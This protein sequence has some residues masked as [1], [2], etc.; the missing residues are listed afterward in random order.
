MFEDNLLEQLDKLDEAPRPP[1]KKPVLICWYSG[2]FRH[3]SGV[4]LLKD[5]TE[6]AKKHGLTDQL[7]LG[8]PDYYGITGEGYDYWPVYIDRL[9]TEIDGTKDYRN[10]PLIFFAHS[11]GAESALSLASRLSG[12][13]LKIYIAACG[14]ISLGQ[15]THWEHLSK[16]FKISGTRGLLSWFSQL[17]PSNIL[18]SRTSQLPT[19]EMEKAVKESKWLTETVDVMSVQYKDATFPNMTSD[20]PGI[21]VVDAPIV[22]ISPLFDPGC[23]PESMKAWTEN[24]TAECQMIT[25]CAGHMDCLEEQAG[26]MQRVG[27]DM[28]NTARDPQNCPPILARGPKEEYFFGMKEAEEA[29]AAEKAEAQRQLAEAAAAKKARRV[30]AASNVEKPQ[31]VRVMVDQEEVELLV[32]KFKGP[33]LQHPDGRQGTMLLADI[34]GN[35]RRF[36][37]SWYKMS[38][39]ERK[40]LLD[41]VARKYLKLKE[42][43]AAK[44]GGDQLAPLPDGILAAPQLANLVELGKKGQAVNYI[45]DQGLVK[46]LDLLDDGIAFMAQH[47]EASALSFDPLAER[48]LEYEASL[49]IRGGREDGMAAH[50]AEPIS[51]KIPP[52][53]NGYHINTGMAYG[54]KY[55]DWGHGMNFDQ[56]DPFQ[57]H[58]FSSSDTRDPRV[59]KHVEELWSTGGLGSPTSAWQEQKQMYGHLPVTATDHDHK[60]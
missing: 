39:T 46:E 27:P 35:D 36:G 3:E 49:S 54:Y 58:K 57:H 13:V 43:A 25:V 11:R 16:N 44:G 23:Q 51:G 42:L 22:A 45:S 50:V 14:P 29:K 2:G 32:D 5:I 12:R 1:P 19:E 59:R 40:I 30:A 53:S 9:I 15:P 18:L 38:S 17:N 60:Y 21:R 4:K 24:T 48:S 6:G 37:K 26:L 33:I 28:E 52:E 34:V 7:V 41:V 10:R 55:V 56:I 47:I 20:N 8:F 31:V